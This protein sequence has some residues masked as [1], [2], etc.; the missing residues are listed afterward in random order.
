MRIECCP[1]RSL[2]NASCLL[3][4]GTPQIV[5]ALCIVDETQLPQCGRLD[6]R[7]KPPASSAF[8]DRRRFSVAKVNDHRIE[9]NA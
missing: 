5:E 8:P 3:P 4:G 6:V 1:R 9:Y 7:W 2:F